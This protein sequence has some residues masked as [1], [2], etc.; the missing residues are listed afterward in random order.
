MATPARQ[1][2]VTVPAVDT[3]R[4]KQAILNWRFPFGISLLGAIAFL[5]S[6]R[7][8]FVSDSFGCLEIAQWSY[9]ED[10]LWRLNP[11]GTGFYRPLTSLVFWLEYQLFGLNPLGYHLVALALHIGSSLI[12][13]RLAQRLTASR[14]AGAAAALV[15]VTNIHAHEVIGWVADLHNALGGF[16]LLAAVYTYLRGARRASFALV[17]LNMLVDE[18]GLL[19]LLLIGWHEVLQHLFP[20][21]A[22]QGEAARV[23]AKRRASGLLVDA[24][25]GARGFA[26]T[27]RSHGDSSVSPDAAPYLLSVVRD[28]LPAISRRLAARLTPVVALATGYVALRLI[29]APN[30]VYNYVAACHSASCIAV[31]AL[32][33]FN[34]LFV[35]PEPLLSL[36]WD[37]RPILAVLTGLCL[38]L[39][40]WMLRL[41]SWRNRKAVVFAAGWI[42]G[43]ALYFILALWPYIADRFL[44]ASDMGLA[45][46]AGIAAAEVAGRWTA[47]PRAGR[48]QAAAVGVA[49]LVWLGT[50]VV[51]LYERG[52]RWETAGREAE[53]II[54]SIVELLPDP[55]QDAVLIFSDVPDSSAP[56]IA[57]GNTG[58]YLFRNGLDAALHIRYERTDILIIT[59]ASQVPVDDSVM[60]FL[61]TIRDG[62]AEL[63]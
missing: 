31:G 6:L 16:V 49:A 14:W 39:A 46:L 22:S 9:L 30:G 63:Q 54:A 10:I 1:I 61:L 50:G 8:G 20:T 7:A 25:M 58:P 36:A 47:M 13:Y 60:H 19:T 43:S 12:I 56:D 51:M 24:M 44:Y 21:P 23:G 40:A 5:P 57:P 34:R 59:D 48:L 2:S 33:Y 32:E 29:S 37:Y 26:R 35:R 15:F 17:A 55:P 4:L 27:A 62:K 41:S 3:S 45:L 38:M 28:S 52:L 53:A 11:C 42:A 18:T